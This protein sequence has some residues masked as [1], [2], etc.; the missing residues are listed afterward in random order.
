MALLKPKAAPPSR[1]L[2]DRIEEIHS[3]IN[4]MID[5]RVEETAQQCPGVPR[6]MLRQLIVVRA[7]GGLCRCA[8]WA[9]LK[10][11]PNI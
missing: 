6:D 5:A 7:T 11:D 1:S 3:E 2:E 4:A 8:V 10:H 9:H